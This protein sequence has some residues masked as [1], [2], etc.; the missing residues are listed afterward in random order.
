MIKKIRVTVDGK[1]YE[2]TVELPDEIPV[3]APVHPEAT[4]TTQAVFTPSSPIPTPTVATSE[5]GDVPSPLAGHIVGIAVTVGQGVKKS[6]NLVT[7][8]AM[9]MNT[10]VLAPVDGKILAI[11]VA[12]GDAVNEGQPLVRLG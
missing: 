11:K 3:V 6:D 12:I 2:V 8:E 10:F 5:S 9:K 7:V 4:P 1:P